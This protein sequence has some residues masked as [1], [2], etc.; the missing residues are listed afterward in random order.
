MDCGGKRQILFCNCANEMGRYA[1]TLRRSCDDCATWD[2]GLVVQSGGAGYSDLA[3]DGE[4]IYV[5]Y[6]RFFED[7]SGMYLTFVKIKL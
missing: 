4:N 2:D 1:L 6:E 5:L 3:A 7:G